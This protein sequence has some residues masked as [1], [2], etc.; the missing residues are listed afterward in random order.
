[1]IDLATGT[2]GRIAG[3]WFVKGRDKDNYSAFI[4]VAAEHHKHPSGGLTIKANNARFPPHRT[5]QRIRRRLVR[6]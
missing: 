4:A 6:R 3:N 5:P 2:I 1:M